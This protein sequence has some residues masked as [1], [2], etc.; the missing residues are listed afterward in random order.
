MR[1]TD[2]KPDGQTK[3]PHNAFNICTSYKESMKGL[4][5]LQYIVYDC[6][7][8]F[9]TRAFRYV[10]TGCVSIQHNKKNPTTRRLEDRLLTLLSFHRSTRTMYLPIAVAVILSLVCRLCKEW[11]FCNE[12]LYPGNEAYST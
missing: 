2:K 9:K 4:F 6:D 10:D 11:C 1:H 8:C 5:M 7:A 3:S 12:L